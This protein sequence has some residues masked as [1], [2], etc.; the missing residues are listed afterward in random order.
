[1]CSVFNPPT[2]QNRLKLLANYFLTQFECTLAYLFMTQF[3]ILGQ[4]KKPGRKKKPAGYSPFEDDYFWELLKSDYNSAW[5][6]V[7]RMK[8]SFSS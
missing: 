2:R 5:K 1:M 7:D 4:L 3:A 8:R 6:Y